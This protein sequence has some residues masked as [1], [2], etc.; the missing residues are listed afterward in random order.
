MAIDERTLDKLIQ[1]L[2]AKGGPAS[3]QTLEE[4]R[5]AMSGRTGVGFGKVIKDVVK[6]GGGVGGMFKR[7]AVA[8]T[9]VQDEG[10]F[11]KDSFFS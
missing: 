5:D 4:L 6:G 10:E 3:E 1:G 8:I 2:D 9:D 11:L 7:L